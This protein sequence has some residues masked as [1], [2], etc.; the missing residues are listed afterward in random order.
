M[1]DNNAAISASLLTLTTCAAAF[2]MA[3]P[4]VAEIRRSTDNPA[5]TADVRAGETIAAGSTILIGVAGSVLTNSPAPLIMA[6]TSIALYV[7]TY[8]TLLANYP[9]DTAHAKPKLSVVPAN[10]ST[11]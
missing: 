7:A 5:T 9:K 11:S 2:A 4:P 3:L 8:E 1:S 6:I 10:P